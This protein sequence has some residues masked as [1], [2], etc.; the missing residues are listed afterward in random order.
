[1]KPPLKD[2]SQ[3]L[4]YSSIII[5]LARLGLAHLSSLCFHLFYNKYEVHSPHNLVLII[6]IMEES[7]FP[8]PIWRKPYLTSPIMASLWI[9]RRCL[10]QRMQSIEKSQQNT[11]T[12]FTPFQEKIDGHVKKTYPFECVPIYCK[13]SVITHRQFLTT[14]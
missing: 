12:G 4:I 3:S 8:F 13:S 2:T 7:L 6:L 11:L 5:L 14:Y 10:R 9:G 1:M